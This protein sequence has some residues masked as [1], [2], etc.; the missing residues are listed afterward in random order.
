VCELDLSGSEIAPVTG[1]CEHCNDSWCTIK[2]GEFLEQLSDHKFLKK[3][4]QFKLIKMPR[5]V[6]DWPVC[7]PCPSHTVETNTSSV[8]P[9]KQKQ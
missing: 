3:A 6:L 9:V 2:G 1:T 5:T 4:V 8:F 7:F